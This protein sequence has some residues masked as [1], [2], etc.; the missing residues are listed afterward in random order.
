MFL[1]RH[2]LYFV[3]LLFANP[4]TV[5]RCK[6]KNTH[7]FFITTAIIKLLLL[8]A[9]YGFWENPNRRYNGC[10]NIYTITVIFHFIKLK[11]YILYIN[12]L[13]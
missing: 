9:V 10:T 13:K 11:N 5:D 12:I 8:S 7:C 3:L 1:L 2:M 6:V 4:P